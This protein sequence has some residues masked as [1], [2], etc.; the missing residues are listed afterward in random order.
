MFLFLGNISKNLPS[1][2]APPWTLGWDPDSS[3]IQREGAGSAC[4]LVGGLAQASLGGDVLRKQP[5]ARWVSSV[6]PGEALPRQQSGSGSV[7]AACLRP[8]L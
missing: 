5:R 6:P 8:A 1:A 3:V 2:T 4:L 7:G